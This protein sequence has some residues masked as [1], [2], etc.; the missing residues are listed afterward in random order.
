MELS[1]T[2]TPSDIDSAS[3]ITI[4]TY[5]NEGKTQLSNYQIVKLMSMTLVLAE[6]ET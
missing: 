5:H 6:A 4:I 3:P 1:K 2:V